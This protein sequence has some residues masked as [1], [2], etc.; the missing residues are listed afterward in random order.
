MVKGEQK[1]SRAQTPGVRTHLC[2]VLGSILLPSSVFFLERETLTSDGYLEN[3][4]VKF[5]FVY[6][7]N[8]VYSAGVVQ[9]DP[10]AN[11][12]WSFC[13]NQ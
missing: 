1:R 11:M 9:L 7:N 10:S 13:F 6:L 8:K 2:C 3:L 12:Y 4:E 5:V